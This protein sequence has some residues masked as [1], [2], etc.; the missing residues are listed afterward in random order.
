MIRTCVVSN[1]ASARNSNL[2][3]G[4][5]RIKCRQDLSEHIKDA[6]GIII[7]PS[8][9]RLITTDD[10]PYGWAVLPEKR[11]LFSKNLS[12]HSIGA[13]KELC[14]CV[15]ISFEA[16]L[17]RSPARD[18]IDPFAVYSPKPNRSFSAQIA[19]LEN[20]AE[21]LTEEVSYWR[22]QAD[23]LLQSKNSVEEELRLVMVENRRHRQDKEE[24]SRFKKTA[25]SC[26]QNL[27][28]ILPLVDE[29]K[30]SLPT[31]LGLDT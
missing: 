3:R 24:N 19:E 18:S 4:R 5:W 1:M 26:F 13:Y 30:A 20:K 7:E 14:E 25:I 8:Q 12:N 11:H 6:L 31:A 21:K 22:I 16:V 9:V 28:K 17:K 2:E 10:D 15:G 23:R 29:L 27:E